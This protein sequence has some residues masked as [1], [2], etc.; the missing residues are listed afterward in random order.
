MP[1]SRWH[2]LI[3]VALGITWVLDGLEVTLSGSVAG[4]LKDKAS[5]G[6]TDAA[7]GLTAT[8]YLAGAVIGALGFGYLTDRLGR[9]TLLGGAVLMVGAAVVEALIGV[10]AEG[11]SLEAVTQPLTAR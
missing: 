3:V 4:V 5:L 11:Q 7:I 10:K 2:W 8:F 6:L 9:K 1:W